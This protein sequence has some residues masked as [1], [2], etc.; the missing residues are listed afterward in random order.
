MT[1]IKWREYILFDGRATYDVDRASVLEALGQHP[2]LE[3]ALKSARQTWHGVDSVLVSYR[4]EG[5]QLVD[6]QIHYAAQP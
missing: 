2:S 1:Y 4:V 3:A 5:D 6:E